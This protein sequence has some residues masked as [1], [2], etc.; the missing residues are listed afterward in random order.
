VLSRIPDE[1]DASAATPAADAA[2]AQRCRRRDRAA[3]DELYRRHVRGVERVLGRL[4]GPTPDL[5]DLVQ[6]TF[7][8][9]LRGIGGY[10]GEA[11]LST[12]LARVAVHVAHHHLR[13]LTRRRA[14][15]TLVR[16]PDGPGAPDAADPRLAPARV[17][18]RA[19]LRRLYAVLDTIPPQRRIALLLHLAEGYAVD[20]VA[21]LTGTTRFATRARLALARRQLRAALAADPELRALLSEGDA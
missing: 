21:A 7:L 14:R 11:R 2:L 15:L 16:D 9:A 10:R 13:G 1:R 6:T 3:L 17:E 20:E 4:L 18:A 19:D 12:W 8:E 5:E